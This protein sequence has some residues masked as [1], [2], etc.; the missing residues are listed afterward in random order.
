MVL[1]LVIMEH[2][3]GTSRLAETNVFVEKADLPHL[4]AMACSSDLFHLFTY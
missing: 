2:V 4:V 3:V 1:P